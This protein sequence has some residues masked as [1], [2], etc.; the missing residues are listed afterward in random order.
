M[1]CDDFQTWFEHCVERAGQGRSGLPLYFC[2]LLVMLAA[3]ALAAAMCC[4]VLQKSFTFCSPS[5][6]APVPGS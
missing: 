3:R 6:A 4:W 1:K 5:S 2:Q